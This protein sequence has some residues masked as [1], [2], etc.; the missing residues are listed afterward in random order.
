LELLRWLESSA[1]AVALRQSTWAYP[2][3]ESL[4]NLG[5]A[6]FVGAALMFDLRLLGW[7]RHIR[8]TETATQ[9]LPWARAGFFLLVLPTGFLLFASNAVEVALNR[10]F[11]LKLMLIATAGVNMAIFHGFTFRR[12]SAFEVA[13]PLPLIGKLHALISIFLWSAT[14]FAG[15]LIAYF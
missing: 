9:L 4:D 11:Q 10:A 3:V 8:L 6:L 7:A 12:L 13:L 1:P 15:R 14:I 5:F 2:V